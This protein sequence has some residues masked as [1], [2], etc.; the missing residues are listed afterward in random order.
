MNGPIENL[1]KIQFQTL[2]KGT[3]VELIGAPN[4]K[5]INIGKLIQTSKED[6]LKEQSRETR[7]PYCHPNY[8]SHYGQQ[9]DQKTYKQH[10][11]YR[12]TNYKFEKEERPN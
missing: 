12:Q 2:E 1:S 4:Q 9:Q 10:S 7:M 6:A 8:K 11:S 5:N 3:S